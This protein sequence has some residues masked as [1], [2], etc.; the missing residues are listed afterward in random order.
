MF[1]E[2]ELIGKSVQKFLTFLD[3]QRKG[4]K[5]QAQKEKKHASMQIWEYINKGESMKR[6]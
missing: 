6:V 3:W 1:V 5:K 2:V 4:S